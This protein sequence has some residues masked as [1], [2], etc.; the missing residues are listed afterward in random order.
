[1]DWPRSSPQTHTGGTTARND[2]AS[3]VPEGTRVSYHQPFG[4][5]SQQVEPQQRPP[6]RQG[7]MYGF[8]QNANAQPPQMQPNIYG[9]VNMEGGNL[10]QGNY[11]FFNGPNPEQAQID[12]LLGSLYFPEMNVRSNQISTRRARPLSGFLPSHMVI[13]GNTSS[14]TIL[15]I[16]YWASREC[17]GWPVSLGLERVRS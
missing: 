10:H 16:G 12:R 17:S 5:G 3:M 4:L 1:M 11:N 8:G 15:P 2:P 14:R 7:Q 13:S 9:A 6:R